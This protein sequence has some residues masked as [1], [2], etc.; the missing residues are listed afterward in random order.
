MTAIEEGRGR[1]SPSARLAWTGAVQ[2]V[3]R[4]L[5]EIDTAFR[6]AYD[7]TVAEAEL[8]FLLTLDAEP[9]RV[10]DLT[11]MVLMSQSSVSRT[12]GR[13][14]SGGLVIRRPSPVDSRA[15]LASITARGRDVVRD[16][17][18]IEEEVVEEWVFSRLDASAPE[19]LRGIWSALGWVDSDP[20]R[21][22]LSQ[23]GS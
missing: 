12:L 3:E 19:V 8:L 13:L 22:A 14:E 16:L 21:A 23:L 9:Q 2:T 17:R 10:L 4:V 5:G 6:S 7:V 20:G 11:R 1:L 18:R 15:T